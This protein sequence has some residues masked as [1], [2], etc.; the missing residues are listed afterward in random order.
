MSATALAAALS[1]DQYLIRQKVIKILGNAFHVYDM[2]GKVVLYSKLKAFKLKEDIRLSAGEGETVPLMK[3]RARSIIDFGAS[4]DVMDMTT[5]GEE[6]LKVGALRRKGLKSLLRDAWEILDAGDNVIGTIQEDSSF[7]AVVR[8][9]V[10]YAA[11]FMPQSFHAEVG[12]QRVFE[13]KQNF[14]PCVKKMVLDFS[15]DPRHTLD[16]RL[17]MAAAVLLMAIEGRQG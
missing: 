3:I 15:V 13:M 7:K 17:G 1:Q 14:N 5:G 8:R 12:G 10:D 9:F 4:Y 6:G 11:A 16:R 2:A